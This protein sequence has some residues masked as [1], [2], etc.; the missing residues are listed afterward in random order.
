MA[1][2]AGVI[3]LG[4]MGRHHVR[5]L[6]EMDR[7]ELVGVADP[8]LSALSLAVR[9]RDIKGYL[10]YREL[11]EKEHL[12]LAVIAVPTSLHLKVATA[13][14]R[15]GANVLVEKPIAATCEEAQELIDEAAL[16][17]RWIAV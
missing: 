5:V 6:Q 14:L 3:G 12:D 2:R 16:V 4:T 8:E 11:L 7:A 9:G 15:A 10:D 13:A 1:V 17:G